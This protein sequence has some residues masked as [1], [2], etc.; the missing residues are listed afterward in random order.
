MQNFYVENLSVSFDGFKALDVGSFGLESCEL[1]VVI[2][3]NGAGKTTLLDVI[4]GKTKPDTGHVYFRNLDLTRLAEDQIVEAGVGRKFQTP[5]VFTSLT[6][7]ENLMLASKA[8][9]GVRVEW[10]RREEEVARTWGQQRAELMKRFGV[11]AKSARKDPL[12]QVVTKEAATEA[13]QSEVD[14]SAGK[15]KVEAVAVG[16][17]EA[18]ARQKAAELAKDADQE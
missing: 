11:T 13:A 14:F 7:F 8:D 9:R 5:S 6:V 18:E 16:A 15:V 3:P 10:E 17:T 12:R 4:C 1:R 2:G